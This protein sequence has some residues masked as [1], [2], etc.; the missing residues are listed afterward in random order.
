MSSLVGRFLGRDPIKYIGSPFNLYE[1]T[2]SKPLV[3]RDPYGLYS[4]EYCKRRQDLCILAA[5]DEYQQCIRDGWPSAICT[6][7][8]A[9]RHALCRA[10]FGRCMVAK[11]LAVCAG[12]VLV[13][14]GAALCCAD[15]PV[16]GPADCV[17]AP[18]AACGL[19]CMK[20]AEDPE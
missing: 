13:V 9:S 19:C 10:E 20:L 16:P 12:A 7:S 11:P 3:E 17:G 6:T 5:N 14:G 1:F 18:I 8:R 4:Y 2:S 15:S